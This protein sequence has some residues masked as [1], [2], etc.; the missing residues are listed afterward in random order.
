MS[1]FLFLRNAYNVLGLDSSATEREIT[2][3][4]KE[5][6]RLINIDEDPEYDFDV[7]LGEKNRTEASVKKATQDLLSDTKRL[8]EYFFWFTIKDTQDEDAIKALAEGNTP[9]AMEIW[10]AKTSI[11]HDHLALKNRA[12][13]GSIVFSIKGQKKY[14]DSSI[15]DWLEFLRSDKA[16]G[17]FKKALST[18]DGISLD[19]ATIDDFREDAEKHLSEFYG[20]MSKEL[21][22]KTVYA[23]FAN[24]FETH[25]SDFIDD[26]L[27]PLL[28]NLSEIAE[29]FN[30]ARLKY[31]EVGGDDRR[32]S[33]AQRKELWGL[34]KKT[35]EITDEMEQLGKSVWDSSK[36]IVVRDRVALAMRGISIEIF[37]TATHDDNETDIR[38]AGDI[39]QKAY[40][41]AA[42]GSVEKKIE[43][44]LDDLERIKDQDE[45][46]AN[47]KA[48]F[49]SGKYYEAQRLI[50]NALETETNPEVR[51]ALSRMRMTVAMNNANRANA[52]NRQSGS[53]GV[54]VVI[55]WIIVIIILIA[56]FSS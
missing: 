29:K 6:K 46:L 11:N 55:F 14:L 27:M 41:I 37:N 51:T 39:L 2:R 30:K 9:K 7:N 21:E 19:N 50:D 13:A 26:T 3:R 18:L 1:R 31:E 12:I 42:P 23:A 40:D 45:L 24:K 47:I 16:W 43:K 49:D 4:A 10:D 25:G 5:I 56:I 34:R 32:L 35:D 44:D 54:G 20:S 53:S 15:R 38:L 28:N 52:T 33:E 22:D 17:Q 8:K 48:A 36:V